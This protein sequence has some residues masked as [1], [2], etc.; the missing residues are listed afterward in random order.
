MFT[1]SSGYKNICNTTRGFTLIE[2]MV[3]ISIV[4]ILATVGLVVFGNVQKQARDSRRTQDLAAIA[5][6]IESTRVPGAVA[7]TSLSTANFANGQ[8]PTDPKTGTQDYCL[9]YETDLPPTA[10]PDNLALWGATCPVGAITVNNISSLPLV[11]GSTSWTVCAKLEVDP[12]Q[13]IC[14]SSKQ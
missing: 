7:Y 14:Q 13:V 2:L 8:I 11:A 12:T 4:A 3:A 1:K 10:P 5:S 9:V 6:A